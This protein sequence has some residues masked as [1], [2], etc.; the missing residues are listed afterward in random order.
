MDTVTIVVRE[1][2]Y[3]KISQALDTLWSL[4]EDIELESGWDADGHYSEHDDRLAIH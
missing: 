3:R 4:L 2:D 1:D